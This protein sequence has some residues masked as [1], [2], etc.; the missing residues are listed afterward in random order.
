[1]LFGPGVAVPGK[2]WKRKMFTTNA[3]P[4]NLA[5]VTDN[6]CMRDSWFA[7]YRYRITP[8]K[9]LT[10]QIK[11]ELCDSRLTVVDLND[12]LICKE[13]N[14]A[15]SNSI[16]HDRATGNEDSAATLDGVGVVSNFVETVAVLAQTC[17]P[18]VKETAELVGNLAKCVSIVSSAFQVISL[19]LAVADMDIEASLERL[20]QSIVSVIQS[21]SIAEHQAA[22]TNLS[23]DVRNL[24]QNM[25]QRRA[26]IVRDKPSL[27][28]YFVGREDEM[29][30]LKKILDEHGSVCITQI[31][32]AGKMQLMIAFAEQAE[33]MNWIPV[34][35]FWISAHGSTSNILNAVADFT[36]KILGQNYRR[37]TV[38]T[39]E[40]FLPCYEI[41]SRPL[42]E[43]G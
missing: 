9:L 17:A 38:L 36:E 42:M 1:M 43:G 18:A 21:G 28:L 5:I 16:D 30:E 23:G 32:G 12:L 2:L 13:P 37:K 15:G 39:N 29:V 35:C 20:E 4:V 10:R 7:M 8:W 3:R 6:E 14:N 26:I 22:I 34:G 31:G 19:C 33:E 40:R 27:T 11:E 24:K 25:E 41:N